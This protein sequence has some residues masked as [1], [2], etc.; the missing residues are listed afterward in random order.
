MVIHA[1]I[2]SMFFKKP[3]IKEIFWLSSL[4]A[5][6]HYMALKLFLYWTVAWFDILMHILGGLVIGL[7][8]LFILMNFVGIAFLNNK[9]ILLF[10]TISGV[11]VVGLGWELWEIFLGWTDVLADQVDT[12]IDIVMDTIGALFAFIYSKKYIC[13]QD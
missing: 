9:K 5:I 10:L 11:L 4:V 2:F 6:L 12:M 13:E 3:L 1:T 7:I 8:V